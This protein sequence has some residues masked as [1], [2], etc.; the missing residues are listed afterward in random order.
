MKYTK[1]EGE[2]ELNDRVNNVSQKGP[3]PVFF[4][5]TI[6]TL[7]VALSS[8]VSLGIGWHDE[9]GFVAASDLETL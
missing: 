4:K 2:S 1:G 5:P 3:A 8:M 7:Y 6:G 9:F